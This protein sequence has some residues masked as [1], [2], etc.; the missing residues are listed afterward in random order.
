M[1]YTEFR[2]HLGKAAL[3]VNEFAALI[4]V[5]PSSVSNYARKRAVPRTYAALAILLGDFADRRVDFREILNRFGLPIR[6]AGTVRGKVTQ[7][8]EF[9]KQSAGKTF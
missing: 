8:D 1:E 5:N 3:T 7:I 2:R 9:R 4:G 6:T